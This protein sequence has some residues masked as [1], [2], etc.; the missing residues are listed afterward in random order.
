MKNGND[1]CLAVVLAAGEGTRMKSK[2]AKLLHR[3]GGKTIL[4]YVLD[5]LRVAGISRICVIIGKQGD[6]IREQCAGTGIEF[7]QQEERLGTG[8][9]VQQARP[10]I[11]RA[12]CVL[13]TCGDVPLVRESTYIR[14][15][16]SHFRKHPASTILT[17]IAPDPT[18]YGRIVRNEAGMPYR[19][20]EQRDTT[21]E[22]KKIREMN[23]GIYCFKAADLSFALNNLEND[24]DQGEYYLTDTI[25]ILVSRGKAIE[26][27]VAEDFD[28]TMGINNRVQLAR[29]AEILR[30]RKNEALMLDGVTFLDP[31][32][33]Y[34]DWEVPVGRDTVLY[35]GTVIEGESRIGRGVLIGPCCHI[36]N[37]AVEDDVTIDGHSD[38]RN[39]RVGK[40][41]R[42]E[43]FSRL[44]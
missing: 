11:D 23:V 26:A 2:Q 31:A 3:F 7:V 41:S 28:E 1:N 17:A 12:D 22:E 19:I 36:V 35:P 8:H 9:A 16:D 10:Q 14:L 38:I 20:V 43:S 30:R 29:A 18:G 39:Q 34:I 24:N 44:R 37:S 32:S 4:S 15:L 42:I 27:V 5:S 13:V 25:E 40:G 21:P 6:A 33:T